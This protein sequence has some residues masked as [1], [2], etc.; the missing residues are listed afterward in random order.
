MAKKLWG[1]WLQDSQGYQFQLVGLTKQRA[2]CGLEAVRRAASEKKILE[3]ANQSRT[4]VKRFYGGDISAY[5][6]LRRRAL[7]FWVKV[8]SHG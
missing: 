2:E 8:V 1:Y 3:V 7:F 6:L 5:G 4:N